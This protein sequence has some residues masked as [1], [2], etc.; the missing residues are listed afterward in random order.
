MLSGRVLVGALLALVAGC[1]D[2]GGKAGDEQTATKD[3]GSGGGGGKEDASPSKEEPTTNGE[4]PTDAE[5]P[6][7][8]DEATTDEEGVATDG[9]E[10]TTDGEKPSPNTTSAPDAGG[11][12]TETE[13][14]LSGTVTPIGEPAECDLVSKSV[15]S[16]YCELQEACGD[17]SVYSSCS[18]LTDDS[19][20]C[21]CSGSA[22]AG[23]YQLS[24]ATSDTACTTVRDLCLQGVAPVFDSEPEC[25]TTYR[26][27][28]SSSCQ[29]QQSCTKSADLGG[30]VTAVSSGSYLTYCSDLGG[31]Y[32][33][34]TCNGGN[35]YQY[36]D[37]TGLTAETA[38]EATMGVCVPGG[39]GG[40]PV[41]SDCATSYEIVSEDSCTLQRSCTNTFD[42]GEGTAQASDSPY[43]NCSRNADGV[44]TCSCSSRQRAL[45][46]DLQSGADGTI[47]CE[48]A[49]DVCATS[50]QIEPSGDIEC[51]AS[52]Q[53]V[54]TSSC[55]STVQCTQS[56]TTNGVK[57]GVYNAVSTYCTNF[58]GVWTCNC[59]SG[60]ASAAFNYEPAE[61][62]DSWDACTEASTVCR[63]RVSAE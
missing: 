53:T 14:E 5:E 4:E 43:A 32:L 8:G 61:G 55:Q 13:P 49:L 35:S 9:A 26:S 42:V 31:G 34:C 58:D 51:D 16:T 59:S 18:A 57:I 11:S 24:G 39:A 33:D 46:F 1:A 28:S 38:C 2:D 60:T 17:T 15:S 45:S 23:S 50:E 27:E 30:G 40:A 54:S 44:L 22:G 7:E 21:S 37:V 12:D 36:F 19:W 47:G 10:T 6:T 52:S 41:V 29:F 56:A 62:M 63:Q 25:T 48:Q 3:G 20:S